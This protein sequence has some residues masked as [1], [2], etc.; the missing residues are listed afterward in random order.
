MPVRVRPPVQKLNL[1]KIELFIWEIPVPNLYSFQFSNGVKSDKKLKTL[2]CGDR[3][4]INGKSILCSILLNLSNK[5]WIKLEKGSQVEMIKKNRSVYLG[6]LFS[7]IVFFIIIVSIQFLDTEIAVRVMRFLKS[8]RT[9]HKATEDIPDLLPYLVGFGTASMWIIYF[10]RS[11]EKIID[12]KMQFLKL[13]ATVLPVAYLLKML[14][15]FVFGRTHTR[16]WLTSNVPLKFNWFHEIGSGCFPSG[17]MT[18]FTAFG[19]AVWIYYP[20]YRRPVLITIVLL[21]IALIATDYHFLSD[22]IAGSYLGFL[23]TY[24]LWLGLSKSPFAKE[25]LQS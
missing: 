20:K 8:I 2:I 16:L 15:Q 24:F 14:F 11:H 4:G 6:I 13:A 21:A 18:V 1:K 17:H 7:F 12:V 3:I 10:Y 9:L 5:L 23:I 19:T 22:I 25:N